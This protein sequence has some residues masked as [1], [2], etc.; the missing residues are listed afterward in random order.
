MGEARAYML[1]L[2]PNGTPGRQLSESA[3]G[4][5]KSAFANGRAPTPP[6]PP[7]SPPPLKSEKNIGR[8]LEIDDGQQLLSATGKG[9]GA[10]ISKRGGKAESRGQIRALAADAR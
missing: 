9:S 8:S 1:A 2:R 5:A 6:P 10:V 3:L 7:N 4:V